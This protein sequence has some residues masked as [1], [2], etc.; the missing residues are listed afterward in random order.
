MGRPPP[1]DRLSPA[2]IDIG[3]CP[4]PDPLV[5]PLV[6]VEADEVGHGRP[7]DLRAPID[8]QV[9]PRLERLVEGLDLAVGLRMMRSAVDVANLQDPQR[10]LESRRQEA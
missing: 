2:V 3:R 1:K 8:E 9:P 6:V 7:E 5:V 10:V 4:M